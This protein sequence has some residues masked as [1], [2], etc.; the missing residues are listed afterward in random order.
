[1]LPA[2]KD[3][4]GSP[5]LLG[6]PLAANASYDPYGAPAGTTST[7]SPVA[8]G[9]RAERTLNPGSDQPL[10]DLRNRAYDPTLGI[11]LTPDPLDGIDGTTT[12]TNPHHYTNNN[13]TNLT[14]PTRPRSHQ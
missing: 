7:L 10:I 5:I 3:P 14:D 12:L 13:P 6:A 2:P 4:I 9:Y 1:M 11:F 8:F